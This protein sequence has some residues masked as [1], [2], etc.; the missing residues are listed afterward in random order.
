MLMLHFMRMLSIKV[1][2]LCVIRVGLV[3]VG[4]NEFV[5][6][7]FS[8]FAVVDMLCSGVFEI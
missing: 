8:K 1:A 4:I 7:V 5:N 6:I 3:I 2:L